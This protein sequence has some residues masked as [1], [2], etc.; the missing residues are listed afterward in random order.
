MK[1]IFIC[2]IIILFCSILLPHFSFAAPSTA[3]V[4]SPGAP[5]PAPAPSTPGPA[6]PAP[7]GGTKGPVSTGSGLGSMTSNFSDNFTKI[8]GFVIGIATLIFVILFLVGGIMYLTAAGNDES[9]KKAR[10]LIVDAVIGLIIVLI[11]WSAGNYI[12]NQLVATDKSYLD[13]QNTIK[14][15]P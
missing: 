5:A 11:A 9:T 15:T 13:A 8:Y 3:G 6:T 1:K 12:I 10:S 14:K 7:S 2:G 4:P